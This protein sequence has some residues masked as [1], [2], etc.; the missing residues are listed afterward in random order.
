MSIIGA[1]PFNLQ[2]GTTADA[3]QVM[4]DFNKIVTDTNAHAAAAGANSSITSLSGLTTPLSISQ[5]GSGSQAPAPF[6]FTGGYRN[7]ARRNG[8]FEVWQRGAG[9]AASFAIGASTTAYTADG[10]YLG[11]GANQASV[12][13]Q[14]AVGTVVGSEY[15]ARVARNVGQTGTG[16]MV[17]GFPLDTDELW[18]ALGQ[19][20]RLS[21]TAFAGANWSPAAGL[22]S[23]LLYTGTGA[24]TKAGSFTGLAQAI[25]IAADLTNTP[26]RFQGT[27]AAIIPTNTRQME[28]TVSWVPVGTAGA[29]DSFYIDDVQL[30]IVP[31][32]SGYTASNFER[33]NFEE[34]LLLCRRH[35]WKTFQY[36]TAPASGV[37]IGTGE[38]IWMA[39][40]TA[41]NN[42]SYQVRF[43]ASMRILPTLT[44]YNPASAGVEAR[45]EDLTNDCNTTV[46]A[47]YSE[48]SALIFSNLSAGTIVQNQIGLHVTFDAGI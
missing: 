31:A 26:V 39:G 34:Q 27:S 12:A 30:E 20:V 4:A 8:G 28:I 1:L 3:S 18:P 43:P 14:A 46:S 22:L 6:T 38:L 15:S 23:V 36:A 35:Y 17:F 7:L 47:A 29:D 24:P 37:G 21:F 16:A 25:G 33:L 42:T 32:S 41:G 44:Q 13:S 9:G 48:D 5:G 40:T 19:Y 11:T 2:N 45:N 10:W